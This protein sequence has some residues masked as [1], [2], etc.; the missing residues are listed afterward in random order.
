MNLQRH[1][2]KD[3]THLEVPPREVRVPPLWQAYRL[4]GVVGRFSG[5][6]RLSKLL[7]HRNV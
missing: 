2:P 1:N 7:S 6:T 4:Y 3:N 5:N